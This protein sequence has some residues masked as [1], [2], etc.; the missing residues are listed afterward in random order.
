MKQQIKTMVTDNSGAAAILSVIVMA[1]LAILGGAYIF[2]TNSELAMT[3]IYRDGIAAQYLAEAGAKQAIVG[4]ADDPNWVPHNPYAEG[5][6]KYE[7]KVTANGNDRRVEST[8]TVHSAIRKVVLTLTVG[9]NPELLHAGDFVSYS[10]GN[11]EFKNNAAVYGNMGSGS[12]ITGGVTVS[13]QK[14]QNYNKAE[15][16]VFA[17]GKF[18]GSP[19][20]PANSDNLPGPQYYLTGDWNVDRQTN[21]TGDAVIYVTGNISFAKE[22]TFNGNFLIIAGG[23]IDFKNNAVM[24]KGILFAGGNIE[25]KNNASITGTVMARGNISFKNN[26]ELRYDKQILPYF[27]LPVSNTNT[28]PVIKNWNYH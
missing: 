18:I 11:T 20:P 4:L 19:A 8:A 15:F 28:G 5:Q 7:L 6:G 21:F 23:N 25:F 16:P 27:G 3:T 22:V 1:V 2:L 12:S 24:N 17:Q 10:G 13:G 26:A 14:L 9:E